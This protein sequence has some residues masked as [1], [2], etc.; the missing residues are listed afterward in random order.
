M[1]DNCEYHSYVGRTDRQVTWHCNRLSLVSN[2]TICHSRWILF[3]AWTLSLPSAIVSCILPCLFECTSQLRQIQLQYGECKMSSFISYDTS[4]DLSPHLQLLIDGIDTTSVFVSQNIPNGSSTQYVNVL[5]LN[6]PHWYSHIWCIMKDFHVDLAIFF[7]SSYK[8]PWKK[9]LQTHTI[10]T[11]FN[12]IYWFSLHQN[13]SWWQ[14]IYFGDGKYH[15]FFNVEH[16]IDTLLRNSIF[17]MKRIKTTATAAKTNIT[18][19]IYV[20][21]ESFKIRLPLMN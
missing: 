18:Q 15:P 10:Y 1:R 14:Y 9:R 16:F 13:S 19:N 5:L 7:S 4:S 21:V 11:S 8:I 17:S 12:E 2:N 20:G 6:I 3:H